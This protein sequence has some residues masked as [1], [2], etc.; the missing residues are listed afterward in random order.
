MP[1]ALTPTQWLE[2][3]CQETDARDPAP[4]GQ[5]FPEGSRARRCR[6]LPPLLLALG[7]GSECWGRG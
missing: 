1:S 2:Q 4:P 7:L 5:T 3:A 6:W